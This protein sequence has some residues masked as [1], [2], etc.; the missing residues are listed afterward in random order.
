MP[1]DKVTAALRFAA[2]PLSLS[3]PLGDDGDA[4][5]GDLVE[6]RSA[7]APFERAATALLPAEIDKLL[8]P[9]TERERQ[10]LVLR[11]GLDRGE[12]RTLEEVGLFFNLTRERIR[13]IEALVRSKLRHPVLR[14]RRPRPAHSLNTTPDRTT[15]TALL[16]PGTPERDPSRKVDGVF[17]GVSRGRSACS[18]VPL[19]P[20]EALG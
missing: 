10:I 12:P 6:D 3:S 19:V 18:G 13:Q 7:P 5:L 8:A 20:G 11:F 16:E 1:D 9:L 2:E 15:T 17:Q 14:H 4:E